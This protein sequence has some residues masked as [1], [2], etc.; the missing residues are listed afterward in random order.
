M[1]IFRFLLILFALLLAAAGIYS[2]FPKKPL[3]VAYTMQRELQVNPFTVPVDSV[4]V[5]RKRILQFFNEPRRMLGADR[6][7]ISDSVWHLPYY[8]SNMKGDRILIDM[9]R[10]GNHYR[11]ECHWWYSRVPDT[12]GGKEIAL[13]LQKGISR[14][15]PQ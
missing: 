6:L 10:T 7:E 2:L 1:S 3:P 12:E 11:V 9:H 13:Y 8:N 5:I 4:A 15:D 14:F